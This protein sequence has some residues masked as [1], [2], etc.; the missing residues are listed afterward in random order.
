MTSWFKK[1]MQMES[2][3]SRGGLDRRGSGAKH[4]AEQNLEMGGL[5]PAI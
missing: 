5:C 1:R 3:L 2:V 4:F